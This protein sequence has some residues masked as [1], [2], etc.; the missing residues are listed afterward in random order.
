MRKKRIVNYKECS[1]CHEQIGSEG[2]Q[3]H[4]SVCQGLTK[5]EKEAL[6]AKPGRPGHKGSNQFL[7]A[8]ERGDPIPDHSLKGKP[9]GTKGKYHHT[10]EF[11]QR[12]SI[13]AK[14]RCLGGWSSRKHIMYKGVILHSSYEAQLAQDLDANNIKWTRPAPVWYTDPK[15]EKHRYYP[16][17]FL[18]DYDIYLEPKAEWLFEHINKQTSF[19]ELEKLAQVRLENNIIVILLGKD[20]LSWE[21][22]KEKTPH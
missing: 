13:N 17:F 20:D 9:S 15:G 6:K 12:Q 11:K 2:Y 5:L 10:D 7:K 14:K 22:V 4:L 3:H 1:K 19:S 16:D 18:P 8:K 21:K